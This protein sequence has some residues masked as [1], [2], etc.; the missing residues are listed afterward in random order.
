ME[1]VEVEEV[2]EV[3]EMSDVLS[4]P[5]VINHSYHGLMSQY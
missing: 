2:V 1:L 5:E 3:V 4:R